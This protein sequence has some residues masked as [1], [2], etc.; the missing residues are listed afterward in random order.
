MKRELQ[1]VVESESELHFAINWLTSLVKQGLPAGSVLISISRPRRTLDQNSLL[2][3]LLTDISKQ[4][5]WYGQYLTKEEW[6]DVFTAA[7]KK[8]KAVP[9]I[10]GG[11]VVIGAHTSKMNK[12]EF[13]ELIELIFAFGANQDVEWSEPS[14]KFKDEWRKVA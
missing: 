2:W 14:K 6:K 9:G 5:E 1:R 11:F 7:L 4:V 8:Q 13:S 12:S 3:P 10:D